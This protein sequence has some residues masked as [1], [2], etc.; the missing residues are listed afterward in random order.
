[1]SNQ[2]TFRG[3]MVDAAVVWFDDYNMALGIDSHAFGLSA[4]QLRHLPLEEKMTIGIKLLN[5]AGHIHDVEV[6]L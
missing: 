2:L 6:V 1:M 5:P 3:E 4:F